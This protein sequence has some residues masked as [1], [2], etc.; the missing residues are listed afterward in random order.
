MTEV[1]IRG[2]MFAH[3]EVVAWMAAQLSALV[4]DRDMVFIKRHVMANDQRHGSP[5]HV[6]GRALGVPGNTTKAVLTLDYALGGLVVLEVT[7]IQL[8]AQ[9]GD[10][11]A[12]T[13]RRYKLTP[14][15]DS[16]SGEPE[17]A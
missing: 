10:V 9:E 17:G 5:A 12:E 4:A 1:V 6:I 14:L 3:P 13:L 15:D 8:D 2:E 11:L 7:T 16:P